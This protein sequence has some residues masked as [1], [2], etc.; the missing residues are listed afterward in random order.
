MKLGRVVAFGF[1]LLWTLAAGRTAAAQQQPVAAPIPPA[2]LSAK[3]VFISKSSGYSL[4]PMVTGDQPY[5]EFYAAMKAWGRYQI[6]S[7]PSD[8]DL[9]IE[10][11]LECISGPCYEALEATILDPKTHTIL[12]VCTQSVQLAARI[13]TNSKNFEKSMAALVDD[14]KALSD[15]ADAVAQP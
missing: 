8:A 13:K 7:S 3:T 1:A 5:N 4:V 11:R 15:N 10:I 14:L 2:I 6:V 9:I 12:W